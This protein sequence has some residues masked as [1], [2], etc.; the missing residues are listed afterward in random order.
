MGTCVKQN[1]VDCTTFLLPFMS[2]FFLGQK[3]S[4][5]DKLR[6][7]VETIQAVMHIPLSHNEVEGVNSFLK[8]ALGLLRYDPVAEMTCFQLGVIHI[9]MYSQNF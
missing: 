5:F 4:T 2:T 6:P 9:Y 8:F 1:V 3:F 7:Q